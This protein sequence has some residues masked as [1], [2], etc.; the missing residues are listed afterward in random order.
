[1][2]KKRIAIVPGSFDPITIGHLEIIKKAVESYDLV[3]VAVMINP[4]KKYMFN[5][6]ERTLIVE[7]SVSSFENVRVISSDG[8]LWELAKKLGASAIVKGYRNDVDLKYEKEMA[9][10]NESKYPD[11]K[12]VLIKAEDNYLNISSTQVRTLLESGDN[13]DKYVPS[14]AVCA[15]KN[16]LDKK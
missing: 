16:I 6:N 15:I 9:S 14:K 13:I 8:W 3:Y 2:T 7:E 12:T 5:L 10:F 1:M 4:N 11:G